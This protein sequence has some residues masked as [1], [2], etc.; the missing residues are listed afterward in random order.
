LGEVDGELEEVEEEFELIEEYEGD[1]IEEVVLLVVE[2]V[3]DVIM[4]L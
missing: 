3:G 2:G 4:R 1:E